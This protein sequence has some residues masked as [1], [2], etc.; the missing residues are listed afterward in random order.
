M[1]QVWHRLGRRGAALLWFGLLDLVYAFS[2]FYPQ[3]HAKQSDSIK[4]IVEIAPLPAWGAAWL[5]P[6]LLCVALAFTRRDMW[7]FAAAIAVKLGWGALFVVGWA[8]GAIDR[9]WLGAVIWLSLAAFVAVIAGWPEA[10]R[11]PWTVPAQGR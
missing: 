11:R 4:F 7:A 2:L 9:G 8:L 10:P 3:A 5:I 1:I 6:G